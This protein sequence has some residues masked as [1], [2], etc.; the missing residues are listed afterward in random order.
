MV[1]LMVFRIILK[2]RAPETG[3]VV[4][5]VPNTGVVSKVAIGL[6]DTGTVEPPDVI[7]KKTRT[8]VR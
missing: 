3:W 7:V 1:T 8:E 4:D 6:P 5:V 2:S